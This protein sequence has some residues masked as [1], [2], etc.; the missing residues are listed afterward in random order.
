MHGPQEAPRNGRRARWMSRTTADRI[1]RFCIPKAKQVPCSALALPAPFGLRRYV[2]LFIFGGWK[3]LSKA[4]QCLS[5]LWACCQSTYAVQ[6]FSQV[7]PPVLGSV[8]ERDDSALHVALSNHLHSYSCVPAAW[9]HIIW[10][11]VD[12][13]VACP[14]PRRIY[15]RSC[16]GTQ[17]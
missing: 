13:W 8:L 14:G 16:N 6:H 9:K 4:K 11:L 10:H 17:T 3:I 15:R 7:C 12:S 2:Q 1:V 5:M